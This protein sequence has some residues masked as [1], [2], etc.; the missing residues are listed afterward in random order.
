MKCNECGVGR[1]QPVNLPYIR[2]LGA[3]IMILPNAPASKC[4]MCGAVDF[5]PRFELT[6]QF[7]L[8]QL[9]ETKQP[10]FMPA[11]PATEQLPAWS[12]ARRD[13]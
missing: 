10:V 4:D 1:C 12:I 6:M 2:P 8:D 9:A 11:P 5:D 13:G 3:H 7:M